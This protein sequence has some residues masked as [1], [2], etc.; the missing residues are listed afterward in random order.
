MINNIILCIIVFY[1]VALNT[2]HIL[3]YGTVFLNDL[4]LICIGIVLGY[5][6]MEENK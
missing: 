3:T 1:L 4:G 6:L 5:L 2:H